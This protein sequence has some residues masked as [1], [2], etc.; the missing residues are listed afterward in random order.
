MYNN[1][2]LC[3]TQIRERIQLCRVNSSMRIVSSSFAIRN[4]GIR[5]RIHYN[6]V[7]TQVDKDAR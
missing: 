2:Q 4:R 1:I 5:V 3:N 6:I 7:P